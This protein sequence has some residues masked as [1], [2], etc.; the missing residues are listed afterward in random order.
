MTSLENTILTIGIALCA[1]TSVSAQNY[2]GD[3]KDI[4]QILQNIDDFSMYYVNKDY[5]KLANAYTLDGK[6]LPPGTGIIEGREAIKKRWTLPE[7][8]DILHHKI[9]PSEIKIIAEYAY[10][11]GY[12]E[13][14]SKRQDG[15]IRPFKGKYVIVWKKVAGDWKI[16]LD[17][18]N[19]VDD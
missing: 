15:E 8:V 12:Y 11:V 16:Y 19:G 17:I 13:G 5:E 1:V 3:Q 6:I 14:R 7:G 4:K 2:I 10:D 9:N 18:W